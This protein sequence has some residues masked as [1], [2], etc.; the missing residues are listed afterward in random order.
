MSQSDRIQ[1]R[2]LAVQLKIAEFKPVFDSGDYTSFRSFNLVNN[3]K[4]KNI[5]SNDLVES[6]SKILDYYGAP[7]NN[8]FDASGNTTCPSYLCKPYKYWPNRVNLAGIYS[9]PAPQN[10]FYWENFNVC[11]GDVQGTIQKKSY[12]PVNGCDIRQVVRTKDTAPPNRNG[13]FYKNY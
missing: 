2:K 12:N 6:D 9:S 4:N 13:S 5:N 3:V 7:L 1:Y 10:Y 11:F 8:V